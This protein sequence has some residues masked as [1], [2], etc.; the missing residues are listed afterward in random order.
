MK[1]RLFGHK[2]KLKRGD[3]D[4][5][6]F[7]WV[8]KEIVIG[9]EEWEGHLLF[10][11]LLELCMQESGCRYWSSGGQDPMFFLTHKDMDIVSKSL[12]NCLADNGLISESK[13]KK[14]I[15]EK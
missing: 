1:L 15:E 7:S 3:F 8:T 11:E 2:W 9:N 6:T 12:Y 5:A 14:A 10:H 4:G 13:I